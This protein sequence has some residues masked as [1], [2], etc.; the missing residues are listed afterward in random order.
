MRLLIADDQ[1]LFRDSLAGLLEAAGHR[2]SAVA[3]SGEEAIELARRHRPEIVLMDLA[4]PGMGG[5]EATRRMVEELPECRVVVLTGSADEGDLFEALQAGAQGYLLKTLPAHTFLK[6]L[7]GAL[8]GQPA[9]TPELS[10][11]VL[12]AFA[13]GRRAAA[14]RPDRDLLTAREREVLHLM[15][16]GVTSNRQ[17]ARRLGLSQNT[18]KFHVRNLLDKLHLHNRAQAVSHALRH[19]IVE[20]DGEGRGGKGPAGR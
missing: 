18:V 5:L 8:A 7:E 4:M 3:G 15:V 10:R 19:G 14:E 11:K 6:L 17:L 1:T 16:E 13:R 20:I 9:L 2:V 12:E